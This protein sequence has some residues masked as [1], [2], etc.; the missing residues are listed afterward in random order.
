[1]KRKNPAAVALGKLKSPAKTKSSRRNGALGGRPK[2]ELP[3]VRTWKQLLA[4]PR[5]AETWTE[6]NDGVDY[7]VALKSPWLYEGQSCIHEWSKGACIDGL[8]LV[9]RD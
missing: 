9:E 5:V 2:L 1:M 8:N 4:D 6:S 7:W 3:K